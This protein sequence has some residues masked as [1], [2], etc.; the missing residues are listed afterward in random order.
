ME[1][2]VIS[3]VMNEV[4]FVLWKIPKKVCVD[5][6]IISVSWNGGSIKGIL[7]ER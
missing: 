1:E 2:R 4:V 5:I 3:D 7:G 6:L